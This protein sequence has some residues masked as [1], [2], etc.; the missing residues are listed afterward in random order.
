MAK[1]LGKQ[2]QYLLSEIH[3][4]GGWVE[5]GPE[6]C[7]SNYGGQKKHETMVMSLQE[8]GLVEVDREGNVLKVRALV[9]AEGYI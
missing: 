2:Q 5:V 4:N 7:G 3:H 6:I 1:P 9:A 8:R